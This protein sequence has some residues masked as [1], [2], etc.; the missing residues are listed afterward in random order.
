M[1]ARRWILALM[2]LLSYQPRSS[3][4][5]F[6][7]DPSMLDAEGTYFAQWDIVQDRLIMYRSTTASGAPSVQI[8]RSDGSCFGL[9]PLWDLPG[10]LWIDVWGVAATPDGGAVLAAVVGY[11]PRA[12]K[13]PNV[14]NLLLTY[15]SSGKL[16]KVWDAT[17]Y[18]NHLLAVDRDGEVFALGDGVS[19]FAYPM[20]VKYSPEGKVLRKFLPSSTFADGNMAISNGSPNGDPAMFIRG[21]ELFLWVGNTRELFR[22]SLSG[23]LLSRTS[24]EG[25]LNDLVF[26]SGSDHVKVRY[27]STGDRAENQGKNGG[28]IAQVQFWPKHK[29]DPVQNVLIDVTADGSKTSIHNSPLNPLWLLGTTQRGKLVFLEPPPEGGKA[30]TL[31]EY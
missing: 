19:T 29:G 11:E 15:D 26:K 13:Q 1:T 21:D 31:L 3:A 17:P 28:V 25:A 18:H 24:L 4:E 22:F 23:D 16:T 9:V 10:S 12:V 30:G 8:F 20:V 7:I 2:A 27:L 14:K 6:K 5:G